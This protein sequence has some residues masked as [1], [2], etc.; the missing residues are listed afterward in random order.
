LE[1]SFGF[2]QIF[3]HIIQ[4]GSQ[5]WPVGQAI[6][7]KLFIALSFIVA[8]T[9]AQP[10][11]FYRLNAA[12]ALK[13]SKPGLPVNGTDER[14]VPF[15]VATNLAYKRVTDRQT[16]T[17]LG[18][19]PP[20]FGAWDMVA[21]SAPEYAA[22]GEYPNANN[23][24][25]IPCETGLGGLFRYNTAAGTFS[26]LAVSNESGTAFGRNPDP[27]TFNVSN[28]IFRSIDP[29]TYTPWNTVLFAEETT[30]K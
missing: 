4:F 25:F 2:H 13:A 3:Q 27:A 20:G 24:I 28:D 21:F 7:M 10:N 29:S 11:G 15:N 30:G 17:A 23:N 5:N 19:F 26:I 8:S 9:N 22:P 12:T 14:T 18:G 6:I 1:G 16:L